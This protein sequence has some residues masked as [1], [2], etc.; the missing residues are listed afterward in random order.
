[1]SPALEFDGKPEM[2]TWVVVSRRRAG[3]WVNE[4]GIAEVQHKGCTDM[5]RGWPGFLCWLAVRRRL[6]RCRVILEFHLYIC[7]LQRIKIWGWEVAY[8]CILFF[9]LPWRREVD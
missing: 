4:E 5:L 6:G 3:R 8:L 2:R 1:M 7:E 9:C